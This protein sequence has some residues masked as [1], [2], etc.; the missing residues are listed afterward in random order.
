MTRRV[1]REWKHPKTGGYYIE[2]EPRDGEP[3]VTVNPAETKMDEALDEYERRNIAQWDRYRRGRCQCDPC[4]ASH[5]PQPGV[6]RDPLT[7]HGC[8][9]GLE[10]WHAHQD[11]LTE[12]REETLP[13]GHPV[14]YK[15]GCRCQE[16]ADAA[17]NPTPLKG[18]KVG[19][20]GR[21]A[22][23]LAQ[24]AEQQ[25]ELERLRAARGPW[26]EDE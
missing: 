2:Y 7:G 6:K 20:D 5:K 9:V 24:V 19:G 4:V 14:T 22:G 13:H 10:Q 18:K 23:L 26:E 21:L 1:A 3:A 25:Q 17:A 15:K 11:R 8:P 16:C 12:I